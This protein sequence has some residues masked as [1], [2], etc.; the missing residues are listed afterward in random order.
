MIRAD[1]CHKERGSDWI[2]FHILGG[3]QSG[4]VQWTGLLSFRLAWMKAW[5][6]LP[7]GL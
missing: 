2:N 1:S 5:C 6:I 3:T 7:R 4:P